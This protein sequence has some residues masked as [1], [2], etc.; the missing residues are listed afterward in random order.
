MT[1]L[2]GIMAFQTIIVLLWCGC[3]EFVHNCT[4]WFCIS[5]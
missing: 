5:L 4:V 2:T 1:R 3:I